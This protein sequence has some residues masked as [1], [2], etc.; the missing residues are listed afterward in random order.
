LIKIEEAEEQRDLIKAKK[1]VERQRR[2]DEEHVIKINA[3]QSMKNKMNKQQNDAEDGDDD[4]NSSINTINNKITT[5]SMST[6][7]AVSSND[8]SPSSTN[9]RRAVD[10]SPSNAGKI[11]LSKRAR[12]VTFDPNANFNPNNPMHQLANKLQLFIEKK[13]DQMLADNEVKHDE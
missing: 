4:F 11:K 13:L 3:L 8:S 6:D 7:S 9:K 10:E 12:S 1:V 2:V 5:I